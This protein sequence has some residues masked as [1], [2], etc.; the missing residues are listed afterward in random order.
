MA[1]VDVVYDKFHFRHDPKWTG[2]LGPQDGGGVLLCVACVIEM[3]ESKEISSV[4]KCVALS[5]ISGALICSP[6][7]LG[8]LLQQDHRV[9]LHFTASLLGMLRTMKDPAALEQVI[10]VLVQLLLELKSDRYVHHIL[11]DIQTQLCDHRCGQSL[12]PTFTFLGK[13]VEALP[14]LAVLLLA[15]Y[16]PFLEGL[17][18][19]LLHPDPGLKASLFYLWHVLLGGTSPA[20]MAAALSPPPALRDRLCSTLLQTL[21]D[22]C[23][24]ELTLNCLGL[25]KQLVQSR[26][27]VSCLMNSQAAPPRP[28]QNLS[29]TRDNQDPETEPSPE[30]RLLPLIL[31]K[32]AAAE[33]DELLQV[34]SAH[35]MVAVLVHSPSQYSPPFIL[36]DL[37]EFLFERV[38]STRSEVLLWSLYNCLL[39][40]CKDPLFYSHCHS[41]Y[42][43]EALV[44]SLKEALRLTNLEVQTD[45]LL[46]LT[47]ILDRQPE[48]VRLFPS[49]PGF[50]AVCEAVVS[51]VSAPC[52]LVARQAASA[53]SSL[54]RLPH[55]SR[56]VQFRSIEKLI[57]AVS[58]RCT[59]L[60]L[61]SHPR[62]A[63]S[64]K[65]G[66]PS[67]QVSRSGAFLLQALICIQA[68]C[69]LA[70]QCVSDPLLKE[71]VFMAPTNQN[72]AGDSLQSMCV[73]LLHCCD[74][75]CIPTVTR[76]CERAPNVQMLQSFYLI[77]SSQFTLFTPAMSPVMN[78]FASK[79]AS[80]GFYRLALEHKA[81]LCVGNRNPA[82]EESCCGFILKLSMCLLSQSIQASRH[83]DL[84]E[85]EAVLLRGLPRLCCRVSEWPLL[86][87]EAPD[88][89]DTTGPWAPQ[90]CLLVILTQAMEHG[91]R[92]L[93][94][95]SVFSG[96]LSLLRSIQER[97]DRPMPH[98]LLR[99]ALYLLAATHNNSP[100]LDQAL[101]GV[102]IKALPSCDSLPA[103]Y[104]HHPPL[105]HFIYRYPE[106]AQRLGRGVLEL[107][108]SPQ[109]TPPR[110]LSQTTEPLAQTPEPPL[111]G[112][113][114]EEGPGEEVM[115]V[116][117]Q[118]PDMETRELQSLMTE[119]PAA[120]LSLLDMVCTGEVLLAERA[121][122]VLEVLLRDRGLCGE[123]LSGLL[124]PALLQALQRASME[125][126]HR[127]TTTS[128]VS[129]P[130]V[131]R[132]LCVVQ[133]AAS[134][135]DGDV[136]GLQFKLLYRVSNLVGRVK[137]TSSDS[138]LPALN[139]LYCNLSL[140]PTH[141]ADRAVS[142]LLS[143]TGLIEQIQ[144]VISSSSSSLST[145]PCSALVCCSRLLLSSLVTLQHL[146]SSQVHKRIIWR[147]ESPIQQLVF[148][149]RNTDTLLLASSLRL[150]QS[151]LE[152][153]LRSPLVCVTTGT[154]LTG[155]RPLEAS[156][157]CL[158]P[159]GA[160]GA[161]SLATALYGL[162]LQKQDVLLRASVNCLRALLD[163]LQRRSPTTAQYVVQQPW[164]RL[165][166]YSLLS[167][168]E[169]VLLHPASLAL[170]SLLLQQG[171]GAIVG[172][173]EV[174]QV[175]KVLEGQSV[176]ELGQE[177][178][179]TL[180]LLLIQLQNSVGL[181]LTEE[182]RERVRTMSMS[183]AER[184]PHTPKGPSASI[185][186]VGDVSICLSD[187]NMTTVSGQ[188]SKNS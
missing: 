156:D 57:K 132:L 33:W 143:N 114:V 177:A 110:P 91:D 58:N 88:H 4:R 86:L 55:Q 149:K 99:C 20:A 14:D 142:M 17:C 95:P 126:Q 118:Q 131:L 152:V 168:G 100:P 155:P 71:N 25:L 115:E 54:L 125:D 98:P 7:A 93:P 174:G 18:S 12:L 34:A 112:G 37:A 148:Q 124:R 127:T 15:Q 10:Q 8:A 105:L 80:S 181:S 185:L 72:A 165:L 51:G 106:L 24:P 70:E 46:L 158:Y 90:H 49:G 172:E 32:E 27:A 123:A 169:R 84:E 159:L 29:N 154:W 161:R 81:L 182:L 74:T 53:G 28:E 117:E 183:L 6:G 186:R 122:G 157:S 65:S 59:D 13:M 101:L 78:L 48:G 19:A 153:D 92:L 85:L 45:G 89:P 31:K 5:G 119:R 130:L 97:G 179:H 171:G 64:V 146:H 164:N 128:V 144:T 47:E 134:F 96:V 87:A 104:T 69:R 52:L 136:D 77:L 44:R 11:E 160:R 163:F 166:V 60:P 138:L 43:I 188:R 76:V 82:L 41:V 66:D 39:L 137:T 26:E 36:A 50:E 79:L 63:W 83:N 75:V 111:T 61:D 173:A 184:G 22:A 121:V 140:C 141:L 42:G 16:V 102:V 180:H 170:L 113:Q 103:V 40:L 187:F 23:T 67:S 73:C 162:V 139:Y 9:C 38:S 176:M 133:D 62:S 3:M 68:A 108:L 109:T 35:C 145:S 2:R 30:Q 178:E 147:L 135:S 150:L 94:D 1:S 116:M 21:A 129:L 120:V 151:L 56:P 107:W 167:S 175:M